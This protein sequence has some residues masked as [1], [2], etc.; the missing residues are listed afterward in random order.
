MREDVGD[1]GERLQVHRCVSAAICLRGG[2]GEGG[3]DSH[4]WAVNAAPSD[5][6]VGV[7]RETVT[8]TLMETNGAGFHTSSTGYW[9]A[10]TDGA[11]PH[12]SCLDA[13]SLCV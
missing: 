2:G 6:S 11:C 8:C 9:E 4:G 13:C 10:E 5:T 3:S 12:S 1:G 7:S